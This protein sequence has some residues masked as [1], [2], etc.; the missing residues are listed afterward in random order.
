MDENTQLLADLIKMR[1]AKNGGPNTEIGKALAEV[2][3][4]WGLLSDISVKQYI[5]FKKRAGLPCEESMQ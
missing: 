4:S 1:I 5:A 2:A 3:D